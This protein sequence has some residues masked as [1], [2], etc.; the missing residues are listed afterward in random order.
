[1]KCLIPLRAI[2]SAVIKGKGRLFLAE[3]LFT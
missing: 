2:L 1:L 3:V